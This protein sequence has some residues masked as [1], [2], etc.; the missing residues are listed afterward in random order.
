M[1]ETSK[2]FWSMDSTW[3]TSLEASRYVVM[4][5]LL[6]QSTPFIADTVGTS[7]QCPHQRESVIAGVYFSQT[8][9]IWFFLGFNCCPFYRG[10]RYNEVSA[11]RELT[12]L[13]LQYCWIIQPHSITNG[14]ATYCLPVSHSIIPSGAEILGIL[15]KRSVQSQVVMVVTQPLQ[16]VVVLH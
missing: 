1:L 13:S 3:L 8:S 15:Q 9:V 6:L 2:E 4:N 7:S 5:K 14:V 11:R 12:V 16:Y 10:V